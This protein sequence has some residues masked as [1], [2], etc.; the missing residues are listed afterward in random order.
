MSIINYMN[1][2]FLSFIAGLTTGGLSCFAVQGG[3]LAG[4]LTEQEK[5]DQKK[6]I[7]MFLSAKLISHFLLGAGLGYLGST[8]IIST[9]F[10]G[11]MQIV[12]GLFI[13]VI[14]AKFADIHPIFKNFS[15][16][17]PKFL[18]KILRKESK[19][20]NLI[21]PAV[22][23]F[24]TILIPCGITQGIMLLSVSSG[25]FIYGALILAAFVL[26][27]S[28]VFFI[29][30][31]ASE[32][33]LSFKPLKIFAIIAMFLLGFMSINTGQIL[34]GSPH[35]FQNYASLIKP[36]SKNGGEIL[37]KN[38][39]QEVTINVKNTSYQTSIN[40]LKIGVPVKLILK[41]NKTVGCS[42]AFTIPEYSLSKI[43][44]A[45]GTEILEFT[46]TKLGRLTFTCSM[47]MYTGNF[48][49]VE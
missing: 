6:T 25:S 1:Q 32:K 20:N 5:K 23:G 33:I 26:G 37:M 14:A 38:G 18:F 17:P 15:L 48:N 36:V 4:I 13:L 40:K 30:G 12:A 10:Q 11:I 27:T 24:L 35:T 47:G 7:L 3:L 39:K 22:V 9:N 45:T 16:T 44:P 19:S 8:L 2:I 46:P 41:T 31:I 34:R 42:R 29:L 28:P 49:V 43:L 21:A